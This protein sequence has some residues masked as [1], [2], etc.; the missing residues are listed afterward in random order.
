MVEYTL[1]SCRFDKQFLHNPTCIMGKLSTTVS[2]CVNTSSKPHRLQ[3]ILASVIE[4]NLE[5]QIYH[6]SKLYNPK[7]LKP[8]PQVTAT[9]SSKPPSLPPL[10]SSNSTLFLSSS[11]RYSP[12]DS[13]AVSTHLQQPQPS[14]M[15]FPPT[16][17]VTVAVS[18]QVPPMCLAVAASGH[19]RRSLCLALFSLRHSPRGCPTIAAGGPRRNYSLCCSS[20]PS[21]SPLCSS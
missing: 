11:L 19:H 3:M 20:S 17:T 12:R 5:F 9:I 21:P 16:P 6:I 1:S 18:H 10:T 14:L 7:T 4:I 15:S 8:P 2:Q 13:D